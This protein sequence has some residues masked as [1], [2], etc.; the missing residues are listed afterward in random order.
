MTPTGNPKLS[1]DVRYFFV[2]KV[3]PSFYLASRYL[4]LGLRRSYLDRKPVVS[5]VTW[6]SKELTVNDSSKNSFRCGKHVA[7]CQPGDATTTAGRKPT[8]QCFASSCPVRRL[9]SNGVRVLRRI[10]KKLTKPQGSNRPVEKSAQSDADRPGVFLET[11]V[12]VSFAQPHSQAY[13]VRNERLDEKQDSQALEESNTTKGSEWGSVACP[14][15]K[16]R[17]QAEETQRQK[18]SAAR[19]NAF[20]QRKN[21]SVSSHILAEIQRG[22]EQRGQ[23]DSVEKSS[24]SWVGKSH[25]GVTKVLESFFRAQG[26]SNAGCSHRTMRLLREQATGKA[27]YCPALL[28]WYQRRTEFNLYLRDM[29]QRYPSLD[30]VS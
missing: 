12:N 21:D 22:N 7:H 19:R 1:S 13:Q 18:D 4:W 20:S 23:T 15:G 3:V 9:A 5:R 29:P 24:E 11:M 25:R 26:V 10:D 30:G 16:K 8:R 28:R 6:I 2:D 17:S 27:P 14:E